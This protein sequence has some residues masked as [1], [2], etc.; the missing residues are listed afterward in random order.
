MH[1]LLLIGS[2]TTIIVAAQVFVRAIVEAE[3]EVVV[4]EG[5]RVHRREEIVEHIRLC[6]V[7]NCRGWREGRSGF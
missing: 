2:C 1:R 3:P 7:K 4:I 5:T 6:I